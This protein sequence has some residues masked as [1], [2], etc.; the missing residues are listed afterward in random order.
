MVHVKEE[1]SKTKVLAQ[2]L[3]AFSHY[4]VQTGRPSNQSRGV[5]IELHYARNK[6]LF[7]FTVDI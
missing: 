6:N 7:I 4:R 3:A 2:T 1:I 5:Q